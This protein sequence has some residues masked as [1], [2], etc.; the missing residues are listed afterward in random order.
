VKIATSNADLKNSFSNQLN[1]EE[2]FEYTII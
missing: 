2:K 1:K